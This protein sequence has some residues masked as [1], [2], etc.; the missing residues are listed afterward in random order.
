MVIECLFL[1]GYREAYK[2]VLDHFDENLKFATQ[3]FIGHYQTVALFQILI[4]V[5]YF[6]HLFSKLLTTHT[7]FYS[8]FVM[9]SELI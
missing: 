9:Q 7:K 4:D 5:I 6:M 2:F 3:Q 8:Y 1:P